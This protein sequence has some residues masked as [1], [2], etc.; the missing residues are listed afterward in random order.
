M[1]IDVLAKSG[2]ARAI[3]AL[4][5]ILLG[6]EVPAVKFISKQPIYFYPVKRAAQEALLA[7][8]EQVPFDASDAT[9][10]DVVKQLAKL[11]GQDLNAAL[12]ATH[13]LRMIGTPDAVAALELF[14]EQHKSDNPRPYVIDEITD[15]LSRLKEISNPKAPVERSNP[16]IGQFS[17]GSETAEHAKGERP[18]GVTTS[19]A[20]DESKAPFS[21]PI[22]PIAVVWCSL[23][24]SCSSC[25]A[26][27]RK[28]RAL[29]G[30]TP[31]SH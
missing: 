9:R 28:L 22:L 17:T 24:V 2:D 19:S 21:F 29:L 5:S 30:L 13:S 20:V 25:D 12:S 8:G 15:Q 26:K 11:L 1:A 31:W 3:P 23:A 4:Q 14:V 16:P 10:E 27:R 18:H 6:E 7:L